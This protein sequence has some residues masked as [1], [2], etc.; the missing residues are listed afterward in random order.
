MALRLAPLRLA[1]PKPDSSQQVSRTQLWGGPI[2]T[3][4][5]GGC[6]GWVFLVKPGGVGW[7][8]WRSWGFFIFKEIFE[9]QDRLHFGS[10]RCR[11]LIKYIV[12][13]FRS[14][15]LIERIWYLRFS[16]VTAS[17]GT[18]SWIGD[19]HRL[20]CR[21]QKAFKFSKGIYTLPGNDYISRTIAFSP[22]LSGWFSQTGPVFTVGYTNCRFVWERKINL[23]IDL[24][25]STLAVE[26]CEIFK[27]FFLQ[28]FKVVQPCVC[29]KKLSKPQGGGCR[30]NDIL[31]Q[32]PY[33]KPSKKWSLPQRCGILRSIARWCDPGSITT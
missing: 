24:H 6:V 4:R 2:G 12:E 26:M 11:N 19:S 30:K 1:P 20:I 13:L 16:L 3:T 15:Y 23:D 8:G 22:N 17:S 7:F 21:H 32:P 29:Q 27:G 18:Q 25:L 33:E 28:C 9:I 10:F 5:C 14:S 31:E